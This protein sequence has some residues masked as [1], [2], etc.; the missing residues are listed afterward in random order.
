MRTRDVYILGFIVLGVTNFVL[1]ERRDGS[2]TW[3][4]VS[5]VKRECT[6]EVGGRQ[7]KSRKRT[8][9]VRVGN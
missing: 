2:H 7:R 8:N 5:C 1:N 9:L 3:Q 4:G 6:S